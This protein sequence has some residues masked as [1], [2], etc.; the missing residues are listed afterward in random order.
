MTAREVKVVQAVTATGLF[1]GYDRFS[2]SAGSMPTG[3]CRPRCAIWWRAGAPAAPDSS[4]SRLHLNSAVDLMARKTGGERYAE[5]MQ[6]FWFNEAQRLELYTP[7]YRSLLGDRRADACVLDL[8]QRA[9]ADDAI[10]RMM[11]VDAMSRLPGQS[12]MILDRATMA[13]G[14]ECARRS[15]IRAS[16]SSWPGYLPD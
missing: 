8:F 7:A 4:P 3:W 9:P 13:Y 6:F 2:A 11:Y 12:L 5:S 16:P 10:D 15:S 14:L 1:G